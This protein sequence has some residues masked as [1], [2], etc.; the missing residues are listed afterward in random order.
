MRRGVGWVWLVLLLTAGPAM[1]E[2]VAI[3]AGRLIDGSGAPPLRN[4]VLL[5]EDGIIQAVGRDVKIPADARIIDLS[6]H[7]VLPGFIDAHT[8]LTGRTIGEGEN[9]QDAAVRDLPQEDAIR[10]VRNAW[11]TLQAGFTT[12]R[13]VGANDFSDVALRNMI[14]AGVVPGPRM[15][16]AGHSL[17][18]TGGHC[19]TNGYVPGLFEPSILR[20]VVNGADEIR[21]AIREQVKYGADLIKTCA[22]GGVLS[23]GDAVGVQQYTLE[24]LRALVDEAHLRERKVAAHAHG[25]EGIKAALRAGVDSIEHG[26][27]LD[28]EAIDLFLQRGA[29]LVPTMMAFEAVERQASDG[30][31]TGLRKE[32]ALFIGPRARDSFRRAAAAGVNIALGSDAGVFTH[33]TQGREFTLMV[34]NGLEPMKAILAGTSVAA[35]LLGLS[36]EVGRLAPGMAADVVAV[37]GDPLQDMSVLERVEFVMQSGRVLRSGGNPVADARFGGPG[38]SLVRVPGL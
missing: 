13:N 18:I 8:H 33:G 34:D 31:L 32:K 11:L 17:G 38:G 26:S 16:V 10:G 3:Q 15:L 27:V 30:T 36:E 1:A 37:S 6:R 35:A 22:T 9:W 23:E 25:N 29:Y 2:V 7:T 4:A 21:A 19:D 24:E 12:V 28:D 14:R 5:I 20:G